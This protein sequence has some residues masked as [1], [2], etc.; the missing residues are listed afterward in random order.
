MLS[1]RAVG[2]GPA[3]RQAALR[4][5]N[6][7]LRN[8]VARRTIQTESLPPSA[9]Q[10]ILNK[11]RLLRP[12]S[13]HFTIYQPQLTWVASI[14][15]RGTGVGLSVLLYGFSLAYLVAPGTFDSAHVIEFVGSMP[16]AVKIAGKTILA[17]PFAFH[18][19]NGIRHL[20]WDMNK[21]MTVKGAYSTGYAVLAGTAVSTVALVMM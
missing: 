1:A 12:S 4:P 11:Q 20:A 10:E 3:L 21:F 16:E 13:P 8:V 2:L 6:V 19:L 15:N 5:R 7:A 17:A 14:V 9:A 18:S